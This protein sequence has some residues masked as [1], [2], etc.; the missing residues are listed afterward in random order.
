MCVVG[1]GDEREGEVPAAAVVLSEGQTFDKDAL[2]K[3]LIKIEV[4]KYIRIVP[5]I[6]LT[7]TGKPDKLPCRHFLMSV[8][9][10]TGRCG[11]IIL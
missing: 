10:S 7:S 9:T 6:P 5:E 2:G 1:V 3:I 11:T 4:P 8:L